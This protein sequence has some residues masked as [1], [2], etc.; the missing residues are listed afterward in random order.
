M[1]G[2]L[3][4]MTI[5]LR[6][7]P[8]AILYQAPSGAAILYQ[9]PSGAAILYQAPSGADSCHEVG[10][11]DEQRG[12]LR[13]GAPVDDGEHRRCLLKPAGRRCMAPERGAARVVQAPADRRPVG[14]GGQVISRV[15]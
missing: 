9:A 14:I 15:P 12:P 2:L 4:T 3:S 6:P 11:V 13:E 8:A 1:N 5:P 7:T 10:P